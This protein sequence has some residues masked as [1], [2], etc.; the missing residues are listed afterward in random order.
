MGRVDLVSLDSEREALADWLSLGVE[1]IVLVL[2]L[3]PR[4]DGR[5]SLDGLATAGN[6]RGSFQYSTS[7]V[8]LRI[9]EGAV[10]TDTSDT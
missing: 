5:L 7:A 4:D 9:L 10:S 1:T 3:R 2:R 8:F 6:G